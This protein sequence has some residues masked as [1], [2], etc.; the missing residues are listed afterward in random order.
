MNSNFNFN[1][2]LIFKF[3]LKKNF[4]EASKFDCGLRCP[5]NGLL[6]VLRYVFATISETPYPQPNYLMN[7]AGKKRK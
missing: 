5:E 4:V 6:N 2:A 7:N 3:S 1:N